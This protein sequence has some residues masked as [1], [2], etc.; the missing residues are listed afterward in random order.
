MQTRINRIL[1]VALLVLFPVMGTAADDFKLEEG[2]KLLFNGKNL[3]GWREFGK[4]TESLDGKTEAYKGRFKVTEGRLVIDP[5]AKGDLH[6]ETTRE[7]G[8]DVTIRFDF[9]AG[10]KCN[11][12]LFLRGS[13]FD[14][15]IADKKKGAVKEGEWSKFEIV[16]TDK[17]IEHKLNG[18]S[19]RSGNAMDKAT[20][21]RIRAE[22]G[23]IEFKNIR[24]KE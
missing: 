12:D 8:K 2:F 1:G 7:F 24:A 3:D 14:I 4:S 5:A 9:K 6:I 15:V 16:I 18:E 19:I 13:K 20:T 17:K 10:E 22:F 23:A 11:N 21:F